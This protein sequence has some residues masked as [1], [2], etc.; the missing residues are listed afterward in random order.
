M[1]FVCQVGQLPR[2]MCLI[3]FLLR[4]VCQKTMFLS[5]LLFTVPLWWF[6]EVRMDCN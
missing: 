3:V 5:L 4:I 2:I 1:E 6:K